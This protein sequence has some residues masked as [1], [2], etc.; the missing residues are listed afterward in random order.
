[1]ATLS[2]D[3]TSQM[4]KWIEGKIK[5]GLYKSKSEIIRQLLREKIELDKYP[6]AAMSE[7]ALRTIWDNKE[8]EIWNKYL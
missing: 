6:N 1:M 7:S 4:M 2:A 5:S 8:D 3:I